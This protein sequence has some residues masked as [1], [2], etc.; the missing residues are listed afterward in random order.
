MTEQPDWIR[1]L[2]R[3]CRESTQ[4]RIAKRLGVSPAT[5]SQILKGSYNADSRNIETRVRGE[6]MHETVLCP[7]LD[8]IS[9]KVCLDWQAKP[10][11][12]TNEL[13]VMMYSACRDGCPNSK[14][15][16]E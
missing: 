15:R 14:I 12:I 6:L 11:G 16:G 9:A 2:E 13:R 4:A 1:A 8:E 3:A 7:V 5:V 10:F